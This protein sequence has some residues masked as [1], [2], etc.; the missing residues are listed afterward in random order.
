MGE[1]LECEHAN[2]ESGDSLQQTTTGLAVYDQAT[3][4]P[5]FTDGWRSWALTQR[6]LLSWEGQNAPP[7]LL[8]GENSRR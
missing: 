3:N 5:S 6:G 7:E 4:T 2:T 1:P 8:A